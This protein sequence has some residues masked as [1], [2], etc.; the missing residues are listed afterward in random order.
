[1]V[2]GHL[3]RHAPVEDALVHGAKIRQRADLE[4]GVLQGVVGEERQVVGLLVWVPAEE[5]GG[6]KGG[7][8]RRVAADQ[9]KAEQVVIERGERG[10]VP[11]AEAAVADTDYVGRLLLSHG[12]SL[13]SSGRWPFLSDEGDR[14][15]LLMG[16]GKGIAL[17][18]LG[19]T[20]GL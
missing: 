2:E 7:R 1:V 15:P 4:G 16:N 20:C 18:F 17:V 11:R 8:A 19:G 13:S 5:G 10:R 14:R 6:A 12:L 9:V 3:D